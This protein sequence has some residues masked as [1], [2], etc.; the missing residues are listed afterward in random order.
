MLDRADAELSSDADSGRIIAPTRTP[1]AG[2]PVSVFNVP[3][4][5]PVWVGGAGI[6]CE[7]HVKMRRSSIMSFPGGSKRTTENRGIF[8][9]SIVFY[10]RTLLF[11]K[12]RAVLR[13]PVFQLISEETKS[14]A[15]FRSD[16]E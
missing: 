1:T 6:P 8:R 11:K 10:G 5:V 2:V 4:T 3:V 15:F 9:C 7:N 14:N 13:R 12:K 16:E